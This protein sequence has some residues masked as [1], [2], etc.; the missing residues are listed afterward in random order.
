MVVL[1]MRLGAP[2]QSWGAS[3]RFRRRDTQMVPTKSGIIGMLAAALGMDRQ[4]G[5]ERFKGLRFGVRADQPGQLTSDYQTAQ[6]YIDDPRKET[7][8]LPLSVRYY[9]QDAVF[10]VG[11]EDSDTVRLQQYQEALKAPYY[12]VFLG[13][14]SCPPDGPIRTSIV[15][16][17]LEEALKNEPWVATER[18]QK[19]A[20]RTAQWFP[21]RLMAELVIEPQD[22]G[23][24][25]GNTLNDEPISFDPRERKW[26]SRKIVYMPGA[27]NF[28]DSDENQNPGPD[29]D[30]GQQRVRSLALDGD[31]IFNAVSHISESEAISGEES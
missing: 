6:K 2:L 30:S 21:E 29:S 26:R 31:A 9:V 14:R 16:G 18:Y 3:S 4:A 15:E 11:L 10:L 28:G 12:Q 20:R 8:T 19:F 23:N 17:N 5:L 25:G 22:D 1:L 13:R 24:T 27:V 7:V